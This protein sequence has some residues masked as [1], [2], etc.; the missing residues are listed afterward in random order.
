MD[1]H[2]PD[3]GPLFLAVLA[4][5][6]LAGGAAVVSGALAATARKRPGRHPRAGAVYLSAISAV[7]L[8]AS[9][10]AT[11]R[12]REDWRLFLIACVAAGLAWFGR[13]ARRRGRDGWLTR[14]GG[15][16]AGSYAALF[17]GFYVDNG[18]QLPLW[19]RLPH[20][21]YWLLPAA[22]ALPLTWRALRRNR[23]P[24]TEAEAD[25]PAAPR[26]AA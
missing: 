8:T 9:V 1:L 7:F 6:V 13:A 22:V 24:A 17:T 12:W 26:S 2:L 14:H 4:V 18:P 23:A 20:L 11:L 10:L 16:M 25:R 19:D 15:A 3:A 21:T 5:H